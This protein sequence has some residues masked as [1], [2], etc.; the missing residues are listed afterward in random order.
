[1]SLQGSRR[2][3]LCVT[4]KG[5]VPDAGPPGSNVCTDTRYVPVSK[6]STVG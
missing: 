6:Y 5:F 4:P 1:M 2:R 3:D